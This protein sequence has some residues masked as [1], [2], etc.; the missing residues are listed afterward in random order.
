MIYLPEWVRISDKELCL[1]NY[2][3]IIQR[4]GWKG[5]YWVVLSKWHN[6][7]DKVFTLYDAKR[8]GNM[9]AREY[10]EFYTT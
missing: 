1:P 5:N 8:L 3:I 7:R 6:S 4:P 9:Y 2:D 10:I